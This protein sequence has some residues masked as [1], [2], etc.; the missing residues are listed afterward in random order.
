MRAN[1]AFDGLLDL[2][3]FAST[4]IAGNAR[5]K[6]MLRMKKSLIRSLTW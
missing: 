1:S 2:D 5:K 3:C 6:V 4:V